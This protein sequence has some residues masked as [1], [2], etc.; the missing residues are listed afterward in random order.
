MTIRQIIKKYFPK[1]YED[2][3]ISGKKYAEEK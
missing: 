1:Y 2:E 3:L